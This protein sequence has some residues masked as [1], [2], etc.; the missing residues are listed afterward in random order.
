[1]PFFDYYAN[2]NNLIE[3]NMHIDLLF[4]QAQFDLVTYNASP[5]ESF[6]IF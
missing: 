2:E 4:L 6:H 1:M 5:L 3:C